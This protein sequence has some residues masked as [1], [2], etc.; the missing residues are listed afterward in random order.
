MTLKNWKQLMIG[1]VL[2]SGTSESFQTGDWRS[3]KPIVDNQKCISCMLCWAHC[4]DNA[5]KIIDEGNGKQ[6]IM[7][8]YG[9]CKGC[10]L[11]SEVCPV[12]A[13]K[14]RRETPT[15]EEQHGSK[16]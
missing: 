2:P 4:P 11:C 13:I 6:K 3:F 8:D 9:H 12:H 10:G 1:G 5:V 15:E 7:I 14:L 16:H